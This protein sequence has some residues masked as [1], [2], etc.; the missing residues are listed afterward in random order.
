M[1]LGQQVSTNCTTKLFGHT[2]PEEELIETVKLTCKSMSFESATDFVNQS[3]QL[4]DSSWHKAFY[5]HLIKL[6]NWV[7]LS[8]LLSFSIS[9]ICKYVILVDI[10]AK[11]SSKT[12]FIVY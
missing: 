5:I 12:T 7:V 1:L 3:L 6:S 11:V 2:E 10:K 8:D 9:Y 4:I